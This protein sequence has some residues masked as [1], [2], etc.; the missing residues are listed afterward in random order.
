MGKPIAPYDPLADTSQLVDAV[1]FGPNVSRRLGRVLGINLL[2]PG[3]GFCTYRCVYCPLAPVIKLVSSPGE[4]EGWLP[5]T[6]ITSALVASLEALEGLGAHVDALALIGNGEPTLHPELAGVFFGVER[7]RDLYVPEA[8]LAVFTN[9]TLLARR[10]VTEALSRADYVVARLDA[11]EEGLW[12]AVNRPHPRL[13]GPKIITNGL[14]KLRRALTDG[15][16]VISTTL[17]ELPDGR[18]NAGEEHLRALA[19]ALASIEPD[20]VHLEAPLPPPASL[21]KPIPRQRMVE[22]ALELSEALES[23]ILLLIGSSLPVPA[24]LLKQLRT[25]GWPG[26]PM[27]EARLP[28]DVEA[29]LLEG[30]GARTRIRILEALSAKRMSCNRLARELGL[31]WWATQRHLERLLEAGLV[32]T[33]AFGKR[34]LYAITPSG[35]SALISLRSRGA[36][37]SFP[38]LL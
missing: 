36:G 12:R 8:R 32:K 2:P 9:S 35:L 33:V 7:A 23:E 15:K 24:S 18:T 29:M 19:N 3:D 1:V 25:A 31:S 28:E 22:V 37:P 14:K 11:V 38:R 5:A 13:P 26:G 10:E 16:L 20:E 21:A 4:V 34:V 30:P 27:G 17:L 6:K